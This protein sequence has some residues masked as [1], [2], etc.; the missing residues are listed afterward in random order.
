[1][2]L[3]TV[4]IVS[5]LSIFDS[6]DLSLW[7]FKK[8]QAIINSEP[9]LY[10]EGGTVQ[11]CPFM[12]NHKSREHGGA[13]LSVSPEYDRVRME[14]SAKT[15]FD[16]YME[17]LTIDN[18]EYAIHNMNT[19]LSPYCQINS[20]RFLDNASVEE[21]VHNSINYNTTLNESEKTLMGLRHAGKINNKKPLFEHK[22]SSSVYFHTNEETLVM[23]EKIADLIARNDIR[24]YLDPSI[25]DPSKAIIR[26]EYRLDSNRK[27]KKIYF[28]NGIK[29]DIQSVLQPDNS[30]KIIRYMVEQLKS[31]D[32]Q[33]LFSGDID[34]Y[35]EQIKDEKNPL[36]T[37][38][39]KFSYV[40]ILKECNFDWKKIEEIIKLDPHASNR[41]RER[42]IF[43]KEFNDYKRITA[44]AIPLDCQKE[45]ENYKQ[46]VLSLLKTA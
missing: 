17:G 28:A 31:K 25:V 14:F 4:K 6:I 24:K 8:S 23:Y 29:T 13:W 32:E 34:C 10:N 1:M 15:L 5:N 22:Y 44:Q 20:Q 3:D 36:T 38:K 35:I 16:K 43:E 12:Y 18:I 2:A 7:G 40:G 42:G 27:V 45:V 19:V 41:S 39:K 21:K 26:T 46:I 37:L 11:Q 9:D 33:V 30:K